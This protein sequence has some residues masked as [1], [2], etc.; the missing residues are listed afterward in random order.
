MFSPAEAWSAWPAY[1]A[2]NG[3]SRGQVIGFWAD[4]EDVVDAIRERPILFAE[5][6]EPCLVAWLRRRR[7][8]VRAA[9]GAPVSGRSACRE[10]RTA[11]V[12]A[13]TRRSLR[14]SGGS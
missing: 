11:V 9:G 3:H 8:R 1:G 13:P 4:M 2:L 5:H 12:K 10:R 6:R 7:S 14:R